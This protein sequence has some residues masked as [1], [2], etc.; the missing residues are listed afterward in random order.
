MHGF[1]QLAEVVAP[2]Q[3][4]SALSG[5]KIVIT[6]IKPDFAPGISVRAKI[7]RQL[8]HHNDLNLNLIIA[9]QGVPI[10]L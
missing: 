5:L 2:G 7:I 4:R 3:P 1:R 6:H 9:E 8:R 10:E